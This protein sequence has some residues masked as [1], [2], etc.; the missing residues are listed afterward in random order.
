MRLFI[1]NI[2]T[3]LWVI[4]NQ[5]CGWTFDLAQV[6]YIYINL[7]IFVKVVFGCRFLNWCKG[8]E[9]MKLSLTIFCKITY[10]FETPPPQAIVKGVP[11]V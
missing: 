8:T 9:K 7:I 5:P 6:R 3:F 1:N 10:D 2:K 11:K 4:P